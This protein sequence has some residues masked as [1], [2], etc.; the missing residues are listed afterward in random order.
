MQYVQL[1]SSPQEL[2]TAAPILRAKLAA[3]SVK[4]ILAATTTCVAGMQGTRTAAWAGPH[5]VDRLT[6]TVAQIER[7]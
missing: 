7:F 3:L 4:P 5:A 6:G 1:S 2:V